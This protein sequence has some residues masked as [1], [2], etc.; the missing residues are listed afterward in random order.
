MKKLIVIGVLVCLAIL[1]GIVT[2]YRGVGVSGTYVNK[3]NPSEYLELK[4]DGTFYLKEMGMG[5]TGEY[6]IKGD[7]ITLY[8]PLGLAAKGEIRGDIIIDEEGKIWVKK[9]KTE[10]SAKKKVKGYPE[11]P[12]EVVEAWYKLLSKGQF[13]ELEKYVASKDVEKFRED[14]REITEEDI[15]KFIE[16]E[17]RYFERVEILKVESI[18]ADHP[19]KGYEAVEVT[20]KIISVTGEAHKEENILIKEDGVWK[21]TRF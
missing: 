11:T 17:G 13:S 10:T 15:Q 1:A 5:F 7:K 20:Y 2:L 9:G 14:I 16:E 4:R 3:D 18:E 19:Y 12:E 21:F 8:L 6:E